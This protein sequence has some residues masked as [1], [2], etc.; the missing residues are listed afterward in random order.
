MHF[1]RG[2]LS[3]IGAAGCARTCWVT[4]GSNG[5]PRCRLSCSSTPLPVVGED[6]DA[7]WR[8][9]ERHGALSGIIDADPGWSG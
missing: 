6:H 8:V 3:R 9:E 5:V 1:T 4:M 7:T 2:A